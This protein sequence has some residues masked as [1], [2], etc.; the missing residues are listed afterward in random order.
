MKSGELILTTQWTDEQFIAVSFHASSDRHSTTVE[1]PIDAEDL[2]TFATALCHFP[3]PGQ[4]DPV[5]E[6]GTDDETW[7]SY[8]RLRA[9][10]FDPLG[11]SI[12]E[13]TART[14]G[15]RDI[16]ARS[17]FAIRAD[18]AQLNALGRALLK[19]VDYPDDRFEMTLYAE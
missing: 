16:A 3:T 9:R 4:T 14:N 15:R 7:A 13:V 10:Q 8:L 5:L 1:I 12:L 19:W 11:H 2:R 18:P 6:E 17:T